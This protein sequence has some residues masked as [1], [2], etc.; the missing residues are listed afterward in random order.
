MRLEIS[1]VLASF[2]LVAAAVFRSGRPRGNAAEIAEPCTIIEHPPP[3]RPTAVRTRVSAA[4]C[5]AASP[6]AAAR[7]APPPRSAAAIRRDLRSR[8]DS[9]GSGSA[10]VATS[11][12]SGNGRTIVTGSGGTAHNQ[13]AED[14]TN[15][16]RRCHHDRMA[17]R[18]DT[19][20]ALA[21]PA[22]AQVAMPRE[23]SHLAARLRPTAPLRRRWTGAACQ[24]EEAPRR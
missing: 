19:R 15:R 24:T 23:R 18:R 13:A 20:F 1:I 9:G 12:A 11:S 21:G 17:F 7:V 16:R 14:K 22:Q 3:V 6:S 4:D 8:F 5:R 2:G 10:A